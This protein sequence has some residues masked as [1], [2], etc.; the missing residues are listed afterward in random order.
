ML[1][2]RSRFPC[3]LLALQA[4]RFSPPRALNS[5]IFSRAPNSTIFSSSRSEQH[6]FLLLAL[7]TA[8]FSPPRA[9][10][11]TMSPPWSGQPIS[12]NRKQRRRPETSSSGNLRS[13]RKL[14]SDTETYSALKCLSVPKDTHS[15]VFFNFKHEQRQS[16]ETYNEHS[17]W[18]VTTQ[19]Q[20]RLQPVKKM[21]G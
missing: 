3:L 4:A 7:H 13:G 11:S 19:L 21:E 2:T 14:R 10:S 12:A 20:T 6:D 5:T 1:N 15:L 8:R 18:M 9:P 17:G 16:S